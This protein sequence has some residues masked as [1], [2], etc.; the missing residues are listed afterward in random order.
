VRFDTDIL[1]VTIEDYGV[2]GSNSVKLIEVR[3]SDS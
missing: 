3:S 1:P 2:G